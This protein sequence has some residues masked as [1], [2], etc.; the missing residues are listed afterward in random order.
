MED[1]NKIV[2]NE[3]EFETLLKNLVKENSGETQHLSSN[4]VMHNYETKEEMEIQKI[5]QNIDP[6]LAEIVGD[7]ELAPIPKSYEEI[8]KLSTRNRKKNKDK[9]RNRAENDSSMDTETFLAEKNQGQLDHDMM[10]LD[11][12]DNDLEDR[13]E[14]NADDFDVNEYFRSDLPPNDNSVEGT[15]SLDSSFTLRLLICSPSW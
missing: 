6:D 4:N 5:L 12:D 8:Y 7:T 13:Q 10:S 2:Q 3:S 15:V 1:L 9:K 14:S 11:D